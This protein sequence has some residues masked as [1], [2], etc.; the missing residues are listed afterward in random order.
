MSR[1][2][3]EVKH[4][5]LLVR[6]INA[7]RPIDRQLNEYW[8]PAISD[9]LGEY[10]TDNFFPL[11]VDA[12]LQFHEVLLSDSI[13]ANNASLVEKLTK[14]LLSELLELL[15]ECPELSV[16]PNSKVATELAIDM[17]LKLLQWDIVAQHCKQLLIDLRW[18]AV[19][20]RSLLSKQL[21]LFPTKV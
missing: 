9:D 7:F 14:H 5:T 4:A 16:E 11:L 19:A 10:L 2:V 6:Y 20:T 17:V 21:L 18:T 15:V 3:S 12:L 1:Q 13:T 8:C